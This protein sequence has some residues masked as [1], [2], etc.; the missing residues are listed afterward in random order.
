MFLF[1]YALNSSTNT[2]I[3]ILLRHISTPH[4]LRWS[5][6]ICGHLALRLV[7]FRFFLACTYI[8]FS[9]TSYSL[10]S[11]SHALVSV[12]VG[13]SSSHRRK[14]CGPWWSRVATLARRSTSMWTGA[15]M[16]PALHCSKGRN[17]CR[18]PSAMLKET[19][20]SWG[21]QGWRTSMEE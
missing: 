6:M 10:L 20:S 8:I 4:S 1:H 18:R 17:D 15:S 3:H 7:L 12:L 9:S 13:P 11:C 2:N 14:D 16:P 21:Q 5:R 19:C